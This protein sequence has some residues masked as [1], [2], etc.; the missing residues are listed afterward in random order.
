MVVYSSC[1]YRAAALGFACAG[2]H[3]RL[4]YMPIAAFPPHTL[5]TS[6]QHHIWCKV[7]VKFSVP[8]RGN[9]RIYRCKI[10]KPAQYAFP[11]AIWA[12]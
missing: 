1:A 6:R 4:P 2:K 11:G 8:L 5:M 3:R 9:I 7:P 12:C 10:I